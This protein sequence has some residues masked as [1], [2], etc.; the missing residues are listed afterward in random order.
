[1]YYKPW[2]SKFILLLFSQLSCYSLLLKPLKHLFSN[3]FTLVYRHFN[4]T[5]STPIHN[6]RKNYWIGSFK[7]ICPSLTFTAVFHKTYS[8]KFNIFRPLIQPPSWRT[9]LFGLPAIAYSTHS[10]PSSW[11]PSIIFGHQ[12]KLY[13]S[14]FHNFIE[15][16]DKPTPP[17]K[18]VATYATHTP[19]NF[20]AL[21]LKKIS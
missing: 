10:Q 20:S 1:M 2:V 7:K 9:S 12:Y 16:S 6:R 19:T 3:T 11:P 13:N 8:L 17:P 14:Y 18:P 15:T 21:F 5:S 4:R